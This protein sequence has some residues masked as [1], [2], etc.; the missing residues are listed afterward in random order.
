MT[1]L[2]RIISVFTPKIP[3]GSCF[4]IEE[5]EA[6]GRNMTAACLLQADIDVNISYLIY[7]IYPTPP[8]FSPSS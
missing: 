3:H 2:D 4:G 7:L 6:Y 8:L 1:H 5:T